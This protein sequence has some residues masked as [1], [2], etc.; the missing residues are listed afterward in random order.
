MTQHWGEEERPGNSHPILAQTCP[1]PLHVTVLQLGDVVVLILKTRKFSLR[2]I[3][4]LPTSLESEV[5]YLRLQRAGSSS[6]EALSEVLPWRRLFCCL[7]ISARRWRNLS[8][9]QLRAGTEVPRPLGMLPP[10]LLGPM[11]S[12]RCQDNLYS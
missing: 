11:L 3:K 2:E 7:P 6:F 4:Q 8:S 5:W 12:C 10:L 9:F 1:V